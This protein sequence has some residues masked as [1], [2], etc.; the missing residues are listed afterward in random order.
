MNERERNLKDLLDWVKSGLRN[1]GVYFDDLKETAGNND[2][3]SFENQKNTLDS[4]KDHPILGERVKGKNLLERNELASDLAA[5]SNLWV[6]RKLNDVPTGAQK[7]LNELFNDENVDAMQKTKDSYNKD[8]AQ[9]SKRMDEQ[10]KREQTR[11][12]NQQQREQQR[13]KPKDTIAII[14][15]DAK[16]KDVGQGGVKTFEYVPDGVSLK[17]TEGFGER[18]V[19]M[20][21]VGAN[22][23]SRDVD[24]GA[25]MFNRNFGNLIEPKDVNNAFNNI[26]IGGKSVNELCKDSNLK[27]LGLNGKKCLVAAYAMQR[28]QSVDVLQKPDENGKSQ[29][30]SLKPKMPEISYGG[31]TSKFERFIGAVTA[32][33]TGK[34]LKGVSKVYDDYAGYLERQKAE[35]KYIKKITG[36]REKTKDERINGIKDELKQRGQSLSGNTKDSPTDTKDNGID[37]NIEPT[38]KEIGGFDA[39]GNV[40]DANM[41]EIKGPIISSTV[42]KTSK[43]IKDGLDS[44]K[45][46]TKEPA[47][48]RK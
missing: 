47:G 20:L 7:A 28:E 43:E 46:P 22:L 33:F 6:N 18:V 36:N 9:F 5:L 13:A 42:D 2:K 12:N 30:V 8:Y 40:L 48:L 29:F 26:F 45:L 17:S 38:R 35:E 16:L 10:L 4:M 23:N 3:L 19:N 41:K 37:I 24:Y 34:G 1:T 44:I 31:P 15:A 39:K 11:A 27:D 14:A 25:E 21:D 32:V